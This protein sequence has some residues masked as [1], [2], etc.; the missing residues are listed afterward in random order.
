MVAALEHSGELVRLILEIDAL[1][2]RVGRISRTRH[3]DEREPLRQR[4]LRGPGLETERDAAMDEHDA[5]TVSD[6]V[7]MHGCQSY[8][9]RLFSP[10]HA[11][12]GVTNFG[13]LGPGWSPAL[14]R[15]STRRAP[16][17]C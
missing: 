12:S 7:Q 10:N 17:R 4:P 14:A 6:H 2:R 9:L 13:M 3:H 8:K 1:E 11:V 16:G 15:A 5:G